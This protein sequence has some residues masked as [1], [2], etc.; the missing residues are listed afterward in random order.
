[1]FEVLV[2]TSVSAVTELLKR[3]QARDYY[4]IGVIVTA[5]VVGGLGAWLLP[6]LNYTIVQGV[7]AGLG[8]VG[9]HNIA[10]QVG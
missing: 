5:G 9:I 8:V 3:V 7:I 2:A 4:G 1:M 6:E 10:R